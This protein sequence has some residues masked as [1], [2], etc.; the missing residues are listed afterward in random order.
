MWEE[1]KIIV[2]CKKFN[3]VKRAESS[4]KASKDHI[5]SEDETN[6]IKIIVSLNK[7]KNVINTKL[8]K[9]LKAKVKINIKIKRIRSI[10]LIYNGNGLTK[11]R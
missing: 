3:K 4:I 10:R 1:N 8:S 2:D 11:T 9:E 6:E 5:K 7:V